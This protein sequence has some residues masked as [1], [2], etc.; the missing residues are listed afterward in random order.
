MEV[1]RSMLQS[2]L[3]PETPQHKTAWSPTEIVEERTEP[4]RSLVQWWYSLT[5][6]PEISTKASFVKRERVRKSRLL[7]TVTFYYLIVLLA[8]A[9]ACMFLPNP[10]DVWLVIIAIILTIT[11]L[12]CNRQGNVVL[13]GILVVASYEIALT[14][15]MFTTTPFD[16]TSLQ[17][18]DL[19]IIGELL[20]VSL[21]PARN[22][23]LCAVMNATFILISL[24]FQKHNAILAKD[25]TTQ[26][27]PILVRPVSLQ[28]IIAGV[29]Y[30]WVYSTSK[31]IARADRAEMIATLEHEM[32][33]QKQELEN[34]IDQILQTHVAVANGNLNARAP[35]N[36][37]SILW[38]IARA[39]NT[40]LVRYQRSSMAEKEL[41]Q[42]QQ[43]VAF[44]V[45]VLQQAEQQQQLPVL[46]FTQ[47][48]IDPLI[49]AVQGK[50]LGIT[51]VPTEIARGKMHL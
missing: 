43:A 39:L 29:T 10:L 34:G 7:S 8:F 9:P 42:V 19:F 51:R 14:V 33:V 48:T 20:A 46:P 4:E 5:A 47:T 49:A 41:L 50:T 35:L 37:E 31:A 18:Y 32:A 27:L 1:A 6:L 38:Q 40:L 3:S 11:A 2:N 28:F 22:V 21:L 26:L 13:A 16:E 23:F 25:L 44:S 30:V 12:A 15:A 45:R 36:Q 17:I 24:L